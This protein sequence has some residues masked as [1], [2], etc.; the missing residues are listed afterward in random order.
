M[1]VHALTCNFVSFAVDFETNWL[2]TSIDLSI[3]IGDIVLI[4]STI[5]HNYVIVLTLK[6]DTNHRFA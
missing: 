1:T 4:P 3:L 2:T 5:F 6:F